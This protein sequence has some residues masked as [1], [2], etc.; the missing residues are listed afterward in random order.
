M[1]SM[2]YLFSA[3]AIIWIVIFSYLLGISRRQDKLVD[4]VKQLKE[5]LKGKTSRE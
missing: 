2:F 3:Y 4:S 5:E 1:N